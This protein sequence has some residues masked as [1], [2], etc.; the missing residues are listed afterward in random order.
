LQVTKHEEY[1][2]L[3]AQKHSIRLTVPAHRGKILDREGRILVDNR[4][5]YNIVYIREGAKHSIDEIMSIVGPGLNLAPEEI[6]ERV[7]K[8]GCSAHLALRVLLVRLTGAAGDP[9]LRY[10][11]TIGYASRPIAPWA[12]AFRSLTLRLP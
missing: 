9:V 4:P 5:S 6:E 11:Q 8:A 7:G 1:T 10:G 3:A 12:R 2:T